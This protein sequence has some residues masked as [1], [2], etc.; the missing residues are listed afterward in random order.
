VIVKALKDE[1]MPDFSK[2]RVVPEV[3][4]FVGVGFEIEELA[5]VIAMINNQLVPS[6]TVHR[7]EGRVPIAKFLVQSIEVF[8]ADTIAVV[9]GRSIAAEDGAEA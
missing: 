4:E 3:F 9:I 7:R 2:S 1:P 6:V 5:K 8:G